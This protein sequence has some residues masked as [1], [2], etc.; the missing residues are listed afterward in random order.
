MLRFVYPQ[1]QGFSDES[2]HFALANGRKAIADGQATAR[3]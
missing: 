3:C 2:Y 1:K